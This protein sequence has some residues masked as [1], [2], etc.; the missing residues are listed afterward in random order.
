MFHH[1]VLIISLLALKATTDEVKY[2]CDDLKVLGKKEFKLLLKWRLCVLKELKI[3]EELQS[4]KEDA[5]TTGDDSQ[6][7]NM[8]DKEASNEEERLEQ[9][10]LLLERESKAK[11]R[12]TK[13]KQRLVREKTLSRTRM[14][15][16]DHAGQDTTEDA[17]FSMRQLKDTTRLEVAEMDDVDEEEEEIFRHEKDV[18]TDYDAYLEKV[19]DGMYKDYK[20]RRNGDKSLKK[21]DANKPCKEAEELSEEESDKTVL[22]DDKK[23]ALWFDRPEFEAI[24]LHEDDANETSEPDM[25]HRRDSALNNMS[26]DDEYESRME[27]HGDGFSQS[28]DSDDDSVIDTREDDGPRLTTPEEFGLAAAIKLKGRKSEILDAAY[29]RYAIGDDEHL[30]DWFLEDE[31]LH[32]VPVLPITKEEADHYRAKMKEINARPIKK[33]AEARAR[34]KMKLLSKQRKLKQ[35]ADSI[36]DSGD[37]TEK[38]KATQIAKLH[39]RNKNSKKEVTYV[40][41]KGANRGRKGRPKGIKGHYKMVDA[42]L[43]K[44]KRALKRKSKK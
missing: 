44:D 9:E 24:D 34:K 29:H 18:D 22:S 43:K 16:D 14:N 17:L 20:K 41:A 6:D 42:R 12:R 32:R 7:L 33:V 37:I 26:D 5:A 2:C 1:S 21:T 35:Q 30:P 19:L 39:A 8:T 11:Q 4:N 13:K 28:E 27:E 23:T 10:L 15:M 38:Q 36:A 40:V 31:R 25:L 3:H